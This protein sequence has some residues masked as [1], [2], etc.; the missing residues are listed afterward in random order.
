LGIAGE[1]GGGPS[2]GVCH[3]IDGLVSVD[4]NLD[5]AAVQDDADE[6]S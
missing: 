1:G 5:D 6:S 2:V 4:G 3:R